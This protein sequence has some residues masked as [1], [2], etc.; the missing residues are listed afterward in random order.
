M[1]PSAVRQAHTSGAIS[2]EPSKHL[3]ATPTYFQRRWHVDISMLSKIHQPAAE[4]RLEIC[5]KDVSSHQK[6]RALGPPAS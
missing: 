4:F 6:R 1:H 3:V 5:L 2:E